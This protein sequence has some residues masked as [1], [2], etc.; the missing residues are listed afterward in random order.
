MPINKVKDQNGKLVKK[1]GLQKYRVRVNFTDSNGKNHQ[2]ER[3]A[4][5]MDAAKL[6]EMELTRELKESAPAQRM[7]V[8]QLYDEYIAAKRHE[9]RET[10]L[11]K[12]VEVLQQHVLPF[13]GSV[14]IDKLTVQKLQ[15]WKNQINEAGYQPKTKQNF[16]KYFRA[17]LNYAVKMEYLPQNPLLRVGSF[18]APLEAHRE[19]LF[20][21]P[22]EFIDFISA[23]RGSAE[24]S[25]TLQ[26][27]SIYVFF[28]I[29]FFT[30]M[31]KGEINAL[32]WTDIRDGEIHITK[33][34]TQKL[35]GEDRI[36]PPKNRSSIR[37]IQIPDPLQAVLDEHYE[38]CRMLPGFCPE[39]FVCGG[40]MP[41]RDTTISKALIRYATAAGVKPI[42]VHDFRHSHASLLANNGINIQEIARR[43]GHSDISITLKTYSHLYPKETERALRV[44][45]NITGNLSPKNPRINQNSDFLAP[46][47]PPEETPKPA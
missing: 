46:S 45:N 8:Q 24:A 18:K 29:A 13:F 2:V 42:R 33:S 47:P 15:D 28:N 38:R 16:Y 35:K 17:L 30:G 37:V 23:A 20:Y 10:S 11:Q 21:T 34:V 1:D 43:L 44:L 7:T 14:R 36:T 9:V 19:M 3:T 12:N 31:R 22:E 39:Y 26:E 6:L 32:N 25:D 27:W 5:G 40:P 41:A 4:Y